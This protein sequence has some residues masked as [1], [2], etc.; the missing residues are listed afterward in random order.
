MSKKTPVN[1]LID[2]GVKSGKCDVRLSETEMEML[3]KLVD[4]EEVTK[5]DIVRKAI[6]LLFRTYTKE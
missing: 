1:D 2:Q 3:E 6:R 4:I 5:S